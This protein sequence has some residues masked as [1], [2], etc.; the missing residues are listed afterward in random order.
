MYTCSYLSFICEIWRNAPVRALFPAPFLWCHVASCPFT[1]VTWPIRMCVTHSYSVTCLIPSISSLLA[2]VVWQHMTLCANSHDAMT[3]FEV[4]RDSFILLTLLIVPI[5]FLFAALAQ[6]RHVTLCAQ[7]RSWPVSTPVLCMCVRMCV[8]VCARAHVFVCV[9]VCE[10]VC[11]CV[12]VCMCT[13]VCVYYVYNYQ[14]M[15]IYTYLNVHIHTYIRVCAYVY[16]YIHLLTGKLNANFCHA[17]GQSDDA[18]M[19]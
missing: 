19:P 4:W 1:C 11:V 10:C 3:H 9:C 8:C 2:F 7:T 18:L 17:D 5:C 15:S 13:R 12:C 16:V 14:Y 6:W